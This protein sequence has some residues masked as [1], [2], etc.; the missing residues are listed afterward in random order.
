MITLEAHLISQE[1]SSTGVIRLKSSQD[2]VNSL[3]TE[4]MIENVLY[5][6]TL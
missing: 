5:S 3:L 1:D 6:L 2:G 4:K